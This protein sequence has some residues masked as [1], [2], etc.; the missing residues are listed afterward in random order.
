MTLSDR[1]T[2]DDRNSDGSDNTEA[3]RVQLDFNTDGTVKGFQFKADT[4]T[5]TIGDFLV[6]TAQ[7][8]VIDTGSV[9]TFNNPST[10]P[11]VKAK[12]RLVQ[13]GEIGAHGGA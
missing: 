8:F 7:D 2:A 3:V 9:D 11:D 5:V 1:A 10:P 6:L 4:L 13:F 12:L